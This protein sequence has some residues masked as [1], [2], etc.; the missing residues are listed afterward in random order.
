MKAELVYDYA[1]RVQIP[2]SMGIPRADQM[3]G[4]SAEQLTEVCGRICYDSLGTGRNSEAYH[5]HI[6]EV[7]HGSVLEHYNITFCMNLAETDFYESL[8]NRPGVWIRPDS[9]I[10]TCNLRTLL[11]WNRMGQSVETA[12]FVAGAIGEQL[13]P[14][15]FG[16]QPTS[17][18]DLLAS[19]RYRPVFDEE[20]CVSLYLAVSRGFSHEMV[21]HGDWTA[22][23]QRSTRY[24]D[25]SVS[26]W[27]EHPLLGQY[28]KENDDGELLEA[29]DELVSDS[30]SVYA[31]TTERM[32]EWLIRRG[33]SGTDARKQARGAARGFLGNALETE[34]I[35]SANVAQW[36]RILRQRG[37]PAADAEIRQIACLILIELKKSQYS[38]RFDAFNIVDGT[39]GQS[40]VESV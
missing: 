32:H 27:V 37:G 36:K 13:A 17:K 38:S 3:Q 5:Q 35:F 23:S 12:K 39:F 31:V 30:R 8:I 2:S 7:G 33:L 4:T 1:S 24:C 40:V 11:E 25:E 10:L 6:V 26:D 21:R 29:I 19:L 16:R 15:I 22:I 9:R 28:F 20:C 34:M 14:M 18:M